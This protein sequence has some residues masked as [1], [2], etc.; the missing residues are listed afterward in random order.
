MSWSI[1]KFAQD[2][3][4][5]AYLAKEGMD[6]AETAQERRH[7][8]WGGMAYAC[9]VSYA[10]EHQEFTTELVRAYSE[11]NGLPASNGSAWGPVIR[12]ALREGLIEFA[13][14]EQSSMPSRHLNNVRIWRKKRM[15]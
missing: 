2:L 6:R 8:N 7:A 12:R 1:P 5:G 15:P 3:V 11:G 9:L 10:H 13:G 14:Y 4:Y